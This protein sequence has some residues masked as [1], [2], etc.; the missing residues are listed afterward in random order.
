MFI[1]YKPPIQFSKFISQFSL[2]IIRIQFQKSIV[3]IHNNFKINYAI[4]QSDSQSQLYIKITNS[5]LKIKN[6]FTKF[7]NTFTNPVF[8]T[9]L[10]NIKNHFQIQLSILAFNFRFQ[11]YNSIIKFD[12]LYRIISFSKPYSP[13]IHISTHK[14]INTLHMHIHI[15]KHNHPQSLA[16]QAIQR[17]YTNKCMNIV[18]KTCVYSRFSSCQKMVKSR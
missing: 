12:F 7:Q 15:Q 17:F 9:R 18:L 10:H 6:Q 11:F 4:S 8:K 3:K 14:C 2:F 5:N 16:L 13:S 1:F